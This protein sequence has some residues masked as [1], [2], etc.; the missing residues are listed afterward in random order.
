M[1]VRY[2]SIDNYNHNE[3]S[4]KIIK[5]FLDFLPI[6]RSILILKRLETLGNKRGDKS[7]IQSRIKA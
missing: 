5:S 7:E 6:T 2:V 4:I 3:V 1:P